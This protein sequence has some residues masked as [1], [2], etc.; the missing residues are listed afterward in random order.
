MAKRRAPLKV[1]LKI[2]PSSTGRFNILIESIEAKALDI[3]IS[4]IG[5]L[6]ELFL[7]KGVVVELKLKINNKIIGIKSEIRSAVRA[8]KGLTRLGMKFIDLDKSQLKTIKNFI[9]QNEKRYPTR[10]KLSK[11]VIAYG[12]KDKH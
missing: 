5:L 4:G 9:K 7:P 1:K 8:G 12:Q 2:D 11:K 3:S 6:S 10:F